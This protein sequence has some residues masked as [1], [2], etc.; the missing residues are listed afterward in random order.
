MKTAMLFLVVVLMAAS[1]PVAPAA[2][3]DSSHPLVE[4]TKKAYRQATGRDAEISALP[5][6]TFAGV[7]IRRGVPAV[8]C[9]PGSI[10]QAHT[11][12]EWVEVAQLPEAARIYTALMAGM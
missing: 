8:L 5:G 1:L 10:R 6:A 3:V 11:E 2:A 4:R 7:M 12:D 9:G